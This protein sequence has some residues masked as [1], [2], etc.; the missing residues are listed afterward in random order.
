MAEAR[1]EPVLRKWNVRQ[2]RGEPGA[3]RRP[4]RFIPS[5]PTDLRSA[6]STGTRLP[7]R[8]SG[9]GARWRQSRGTEIRAPGGLHRGIS[10]QRTRSPARHVAMPRSGPYRGGHARTVCPK[11]NLLRLNIMENRTLGKGCRSLSAA[12]AAAAGGAIPRRADGV[13]R[14]G[15]SRA[16]A[17]RS[18]GG[19]PTGG[20]VDTASLYAVARPP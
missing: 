9:S 19:I 6:C 12:P 3:E 2:R 13:P 5:V 7:V 1:P 8:P 18:E 14:D 16:R 4:W 15:A 10:R 20:C 17:A 11:M